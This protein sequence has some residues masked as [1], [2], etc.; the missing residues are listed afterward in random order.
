[1][2]KKVTSNVVKGL[3]ISLILIV[4]SMVLYFTGME[5]NKGLASIQYLIMLA[6]IIWACINYANQMD[7]NVTF[8]NVFAH[9][10]K[11]TAVI[12]VIMIVYSVIAV[13]FLFPEMIDKAIDQS[14][15]ELEKRDMSEDQME[16]AIDISK[17]F[18]LPFM[19]GGILVIYMV[20][21][22]ISSLVGA[23]VAK[24]NPQSPFPQG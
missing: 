17:K 21:G 13:K 2:E 12:T 24:K 10:F 19:I 18:F 22:L 6:G 23:G 4:F 7:N 16:T 20:V 14:R 9:G 3:V 5:M 1:M 15:V 11:T 8:G